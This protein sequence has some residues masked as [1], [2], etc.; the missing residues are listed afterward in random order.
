M[1]SAR[2]VA[3]KSGLDAWVLVIRLA[4]GET[5]TYPCEARTVDRY[6]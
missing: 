3:P 5:T 4:L 6:S 1:I 2:W